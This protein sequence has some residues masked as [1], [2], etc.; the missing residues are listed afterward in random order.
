MDEMLN[1][2]GQVNPHW[3]AF[4]Q[5]LDILGLTE[6]ESRDEEVKR[7]LRENGVTYVLHGE[8]QGHRPWELD[9]IPFIISDTLTGKPSLMDLSSAPNS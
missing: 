4:M 2:D 8:Q 5:A 7:L 3:H 1:R 9:P 6:M